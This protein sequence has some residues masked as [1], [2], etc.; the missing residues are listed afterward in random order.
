MSYTGYM[1]YIVEADEALK[2]MSAAL[3]GVDDLTLDFDFRT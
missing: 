2:R 3:G 1:G